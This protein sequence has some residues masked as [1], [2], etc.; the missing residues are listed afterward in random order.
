MTLRNHL[1]PVERALADAST[2]RQ[3]VVRGGALAETGRLAREMFPGRTAVVVADNTTFRIAGEAV[4]SS[5]REAGVTAEEPIV[6]PAEPTLRP[7]L[8]NVAT[9]RARLGPDSLPIAVGSGTLNDLTK[10]AAHEA[11]LPY[12]V[13]ATAASMDGYTAS[14][15]ALI[16]DGVKQTFPCEA[17][18]A[19]VADLDVIAAAPDGMTASGYGDLIGKVTA[20]ADW[21]LADA[22]GIEPILPDIWEMVQGPLPGMIADP[23]RYFRGDRDE[24]EQLFDGLVITG[25]AIQAAG[26]TRP[27]SGSEHQFSHLWEMRGL[28]H[29]GELVSHG[30]KVG[31]GTIVSTTIYERLLATPVDRLDIDRAVAAW[32]SWPEMEAIIRRTHDHPALIE[33]ALEECHAK[34]LT[35]DALA[36]RLTRLRTEW[37]ALAPKLRAQLLPVDDLRRMLE[38]AHCPTRPED[39]GLTMAQMRESYLAAGQIRRRYTVF[40]IVLEAGLLGTFVDEIFGPDGYWATSEGVATS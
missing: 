26:F 29:E 11:G 37:P 34:H 10:R 38:A 5:L 33:K 17:P 13:V 19:V 16:A 12:L 31:L 23:A 14:G 21:L 20:G 2:T 18:L 1:S 36:E 6:F 15:A 22:L 9:V 24:I 25:L 39:I 40:D 3:V 30:K 28:E 8:R 32:P 4:L 35:P 27:A 7:D